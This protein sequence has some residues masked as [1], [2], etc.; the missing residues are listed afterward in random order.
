[1]LLEQTKSE[2]IMKIGET[3]RRDNNK[4]QSMA[5][6]CDSYKTLVSLFPLVE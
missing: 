5:N 6:Q 4:S 3:K 2:F 1:M